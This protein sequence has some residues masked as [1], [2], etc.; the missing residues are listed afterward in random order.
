MDQLLKMLDNVYRLDD[1][2]IFRGQKGENNWIDI[3]HPHIRMV[4]KRA[5]N[6]IFTERGHI[7]LANIKAIKDDGVYS[8][9]PV[10]VDP[11]F[12]WITAGI[13]LPQLGII[14]VYNDNLD[15]RWVKGEKR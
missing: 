4:V 13:E 9:V 12:G 3:E 5:Q 6:I 1:L 7:N 14:V 10:E 11:N 2:E 8:V 15:N